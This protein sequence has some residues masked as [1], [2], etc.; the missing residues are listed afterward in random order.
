MVYFGNTPVKIEKVANHPSLLKTDSNLFLEK[1]QSDSKNELNKTKVYLLTTQKSKKKQ[2]LLIQPES[3]LDK[4]QSHINRRHSKFIEKIKTNQAKNIYEGHTN[5]LK[6]N[7]R[8]LEKNAQGLIVLP[9][10][11]NFSL[12]KP[13]TS[14]KMSAKFHTYGRQNFRDNQS[15]FSTKQEKPKAICPVFFDKLSAEE[16]LLQNCESSFFEKS[17]KSKKVI[18]EFYHQH[19]KQKEAANQKFLEKMTSFQEK[20][21]VQYEKLNQLQT[22]KTESKQNF[23]LNSLK[24]RVI[25]TRIKRLEESKA[26]QI[27]TYIGKKRYFDQT[28][29][30][31]EDTFD[32]LKSVAKDNKE[33]GVSK[34]IGKAKVISVG[35]GDL[36]SS[37]S[38]LP[39]TNDLK[40]FEF[41][42][43]PETQN[44]NEK[45]LISIF[46]KKLSFG[47]RKNDSTKEI[48]TFKLKSSTFK[49][50][51]K[52][53][54]EKL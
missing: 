33:N 21:D 24:K 1:E 23:T 27:M 6:F 34:Q 2:L 16:F 15:Y 7:L 12:E 44:I 22:K 47:K 49:N 37:Y 26:D 14:A 3:R 18:I 53:Y 35:L 41:L 11:D 40:S 48:P 29:K 20:L 30:N 17:S 31:Y 51:Q 46:E 50:Y 10:L 9:K 32:F 36:I 52:K 42:F 5:K 8:K 19:L 25:K 45:P 43:F 54:F 38:S 4:E 13:V 28:F 39:K